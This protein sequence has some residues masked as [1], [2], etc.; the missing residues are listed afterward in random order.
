[1]RTVQSHTQAK[2]IERTIKAAPFGF[3]R[4]GTMGDPCHAWEETVQTIEW[5]APYAIPVIITKHWRRASDDQ[6]RRLV[7]CG[8][9][10]NTSVSA[11][12]SQVRLA[13]RKAE[14]RRYAEIG[15]TSVSRVVSC[16]FNTDDPIGERMGSVQRQLFSLRPMIDNPLRIPATHY[17]VQ[18]GLVRLM[19][20]QLRLSLKPQ[21]ACLHLRSQQIHQALTVLVGS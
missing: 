12:D 21:P 10:I 20:E 5:L 17:L 11:I 14:I 19:Q 1:V 16:D 8:A 6:L 18:A 7:Q 15:G 4:I 9:I 3:F 2:M 13:W